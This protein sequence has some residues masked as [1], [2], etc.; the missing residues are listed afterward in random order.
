MLLFDRLFAVQ[1]QMSNWTLHSLEPPKYYHLGKW[2]D[3]HHPR[4][5]VWVLPEVSS[6]T[7]DTPDGEYQ[8]CVLTMYDT[9]QMS[10][11]WRPTRKHP[12]QR[13]R[14]VFDLTRRYMLQVHDADDGFWENFYQDFPGSDYKYLLVNQPLS[15]ENL[16]KVFDR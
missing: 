10:R 5:L 14:D 8:F 4:G 1:H 9:L 7:Y 6:C 12:T 11:P 15:R 16:A 13:P 2:V 3:S